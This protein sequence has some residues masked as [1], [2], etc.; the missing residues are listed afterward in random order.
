MRRSLTG[1]S[2]IDHLAEPLQWKHNPG[3]M[4]AV[5]QEVESG[6]RSSRSCTL[7]DRLSRP[8]QKIS[9]SSYSRKWEINIQN[10]VMRLP[11]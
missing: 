11:C 9:D 3:Q 5:V 10:S 7:K 2:M 8:V 4:H 1:F 6:K